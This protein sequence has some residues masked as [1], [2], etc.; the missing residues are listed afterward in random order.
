MADSILALT[1]AHAT[2]RIRELLETL[3]CNRD[4]ESRMDDILRLLA[5]EVRKA[6]DNDE[7]LA[8]IQEARESR[9]FDRK[10]EIANK[11]LPPYQ[12]IDGIPSPFDI[13]HDLMSDGLHRRTELECL[14]TFDRCRLAFELFFKRLKTHRDEANMYTEELKKLTAVRNTT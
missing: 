14:A 7:D 10:I 8:R 2:G 9:T 4:V 6:N 13:F 3:S 11:V 1:A 12:R 5:E